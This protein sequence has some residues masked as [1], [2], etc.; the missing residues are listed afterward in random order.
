MICLPLHIVSIG[1]IMAM[2]SHCFCGFLQTYAVVCICEV[3]VNIMMDRR[4]IFR[5][6]AIAIGRPGLK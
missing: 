6:Q 5:T 2:L 3:F 1:V 4:S